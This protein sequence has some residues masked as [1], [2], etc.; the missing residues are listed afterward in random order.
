VRLVAEHVPLAFRLA[1]YWV[2]RVPG[3]RRDDVVSDALLGLVE[4]GRRFSPDLGGDFC[5]YATPCIRGAILDGFR[6]GGVVRV[7]R[8]AHERGASVQTV[9]LDGYHGAVAPFEPTTID[10]KYLRSALE[11]LPRR[12]AL[13]LSLVYFEDMTLAEVGEAL[14]VSESRV[15]QI[16][17]RALRRLR[18]M[19]EAT[20][21]DGEVV[22]PPE[23]SE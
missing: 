14:G 6:R 19:L 8:R 18:E 12:E 7:G 1:G 16:R 3:S 5:S 22:H 20:S 17:S 21:T 11:Q 23:A 2:R 4:A 10:R 9:S 15:G 13:V